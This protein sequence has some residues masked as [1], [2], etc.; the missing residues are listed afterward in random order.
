MQLDKKRSSVAPKPKRKKPKRRK[1][2]PPQGFF[3]KDDDGVTVH[4]E[5]VITASERNE[6]F[7]DLKEVIEELG[8][9][10]EEVA[11]EELQK[12]ADEEKNKEQEAFESAMWNKWFRE[13]RDARKKGFEHCPILKSLIT[14]LL[15]ERHEKFGLAD[16]QPYDVL[17]EVYAT[18]DTEV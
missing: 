6:V 14:S 5:I 2:N 9:S 15:T 7:D 17:A 16:L 12:E 1:L 18:I 8:G 4:S 11:E 10:W 13:E 3:T